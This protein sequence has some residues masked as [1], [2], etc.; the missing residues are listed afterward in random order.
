MWLVL[1][2]NMNVP[3]RFSLIAGQMSQW[4]S[5][6]LSLR[7]TPCARYLYLV[8]NSTFHTGLHIICYNI[9]RANCYRKVRELHHLRCITSGASPLVHHLWCITSGASPLVHHLWCITYGASVSWLTRVISVK[10]SAGI[11][12]HQSHISQV[13]ANAYSVTQWVSDSV[14]PITSRASCDAKNLWR[15]WTMW[16]AARWWWPRPGSCLTSSSGK[17][18]PTSSGSPACTSWRLELVLIESISCPGLS[19][20]LWCGL[21]SA[22][23][24]S[25][26]KEVHPVLHS[27]NRNTPR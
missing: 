4:A 15:P 9:T 21:C 24:L 7:S 18:S 14:T 5:I 19:L 17:S 10:S 11:I 2:V 12:T 1:N 3:S 27:T 13:S 22:K 8:S 25:L 6:I 23:R 20:S 26:H 16:R